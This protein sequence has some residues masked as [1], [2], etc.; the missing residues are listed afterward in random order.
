MCD[1]IAK[2]LGRLSDLSFR[3]R[4]AGGRGQGVGDVSGGGWLCGL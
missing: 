3:G 2:G 1:R 4:L